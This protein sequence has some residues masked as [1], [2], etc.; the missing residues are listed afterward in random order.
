MSWT[1]PIFVGTFS[2]AERRIMDCIF[3]SAWLRASS[4]RLV[5]PDAANAERQ[6]TRL[7]LIVTQM[8]SRRECS[9]GELSDAAFRQ[10][11]DSEPSSR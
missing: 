4:T 6:R 3:E 9:I 10:F 1:E 8:M 5:H 2:A 11:K 7:A